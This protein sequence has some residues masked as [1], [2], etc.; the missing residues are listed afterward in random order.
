MSTLQSTSRFA[1]WRFSQEWAG[2]KEGLDLLELGVP[3]D[4]PAKFDAG[5]LTDVGRS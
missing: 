1:G 4:L 2:A 3:V 5:L